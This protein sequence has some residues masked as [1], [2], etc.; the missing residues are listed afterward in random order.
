MTLAGLDLRLALA[1]VFCIGCIA[2]VLAIVVAVLL[3]FRHESAK[4]DWE[5][6]EA[7]KKPWIS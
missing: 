6:T 5:L 1:A 3:W 4:F 7:R 2:G